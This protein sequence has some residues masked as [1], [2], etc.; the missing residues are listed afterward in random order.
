MAHR[1]ERNETIYYR[2][3][4]QCS[5]GRFVC[6]TGITDE[7]AERKAALEQEKLEYYLSLPKTEKLKVLLSK[8]LHDTPHREATKLI[9]ELL[10][11]VLE[12]K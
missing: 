7:E 12:D 9:G 1:I 2:A 6:A 4:R 10:L 3:D 5:D 8:E 11:E